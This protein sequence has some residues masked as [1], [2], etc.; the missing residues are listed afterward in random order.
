[1]SALI[2]SPCHVLPSL[3]SSAPHRAIRSAVLH[4][5]PVSGRSVRP[6]CEAATFPSRRTTAHCRV[7]ITGSERFALAACA[8]VS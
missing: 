5:Q 6:P 2:P 1:V 3:A 8:V 4:A 7:T